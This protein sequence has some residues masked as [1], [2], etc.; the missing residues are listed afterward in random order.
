[1]KN[2]VSVDLP[3][4][5]C[6]VR[7]SKDSEDMLGDEKKMFYSV[8]LVVQ[9]DKHLRQISD[10]ERTVKCM[11]DTNVFNVKSKPMEDALFNEILDKK[12]HR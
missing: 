1:M 10:Q 11:V 3:T 4:S 6:G 5:G 8:T 2:S 7:L 9:Q 12:D